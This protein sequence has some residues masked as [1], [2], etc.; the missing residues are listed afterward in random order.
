ME[1][2]KEIIIIG[3]GIAG[4]AAGC[5]AQMN[6]FRSRIFELH[7]LPGGLCTSW[8]RK[9]YIFDGSIH[10]LF[11]SASDQPFNRIWQELGVANR[12]FIN[13]EELM[14]VVGSEGQTLIVHADPD[15]LE[16]HMKAHSPRDAHIIDQLTAGVRTFMDFDLEMLQA[17]PKSIMSAAELANLGRSLLPYTLPLARFGRLTARE[18]AERFTSPFLRRAIV[19]MFGWPDIPV[20]VGM[21]LLAYTAAGNAGFPVGGSLAFARDLEKRYLDLGG[22]IHYKSQVEKILVKHDRAVG[23]RLYDDSEHR[24]DWI[25]SAADGRGTIFHMLDG[26]YV[27]R[28]IK[29]TYDGRLPIHTQ[30]Q[31]SLGVDMDFSREP[32]WTVYLQ[33]E[34]L[35]IAGENHNQFGLKHY[36]FDRT[37][38]PPG[39]SAVIVAIDSNYGYWQRIYGRRL[40]DMEQRQVAEVVLDKLETLYPGIR[41]HIEVKDVATPL[42]YERYTGSW[43]GSTCGWLLTDKSMM[44]MVRGMNKT[45]PGLRNFVMAGQWVEPGGSVPVVALSGRNAIQLI[46]AADERPFETACP[47]AAGTAA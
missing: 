39:K 21:F 24:A 32:H 22:T 33:D 46:C 13:H 9:G 19:P 26:K 29:R 17:K 20:M 44:M 14:R 40:Y 28:E 36:A 30:M 47:V 25:I 5:Y 23:V 42:S 8:E 37:L 43:M 1:P 34:P 11:G 16:E 15:R 6:G 2:T 7:T 12:A 45:L 27:D 31:V 38:A 10:Y 4:L 3:A 35:L 18:Y 41:S